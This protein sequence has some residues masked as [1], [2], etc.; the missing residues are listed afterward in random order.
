MQNLESSCFFCAPSWAAINHNTNHMEV[1]MVHSNESLDIYRI[2]AIAQHP[3]MLQT[4]Q[5]SDEHNFLDRGLVREA[6]ENRRALVMAALNGL[7]LQANKSLA[8]LQNAVTLDESLTVAE[9]G[10]RMGYPTKLFG[11][12]SA[13]G[14][15]AAMSGGVAVFESDCH[16]WGVMLARNADVEVPVEALEVLTKLRMAGAHVESL[17]IGRATAHAKPSLRRAVAEEFGHLHTRMHTA[18]MTAGRALED[19]F[20]FTADPVLL[21]TLE[22]S[23]YVVECYRWG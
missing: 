3:V 13:D 9:L 17:F 20:S 11:M 2:P 15:R 7:D 18:L 4:L 22:N 16:S 6:A 10:R 14:Y 19:A 21:L 1:V 12:F 5:R 8:A 23:L